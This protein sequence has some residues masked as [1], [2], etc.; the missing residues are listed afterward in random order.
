MSATDETPPPDALSATLV[1]VG[2]NLGDHG[3]T[4]HRAV[5][6]LPTDTVRDLLDRVI[7]PP[8]KYRKRDY[9][10]HVIL[11]FVEPAS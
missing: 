8:G 5:E 3:E 10:H 2:V 11:R 9:D 7:P 6:V 4:I 1:Q